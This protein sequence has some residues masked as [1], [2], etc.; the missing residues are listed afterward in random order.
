MH[1]LTS[2]VSRDDGKTTE[3]AASGEE[4]DGQGAFLSLAQFMQVNSPY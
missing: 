1:G 3:L 2:R 4:H